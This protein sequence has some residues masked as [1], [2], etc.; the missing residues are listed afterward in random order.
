MTLLLDYSLFFTYF[1]VT[2]HLSHQCQSQGTG[3]L[4]STEFAVQGC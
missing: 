1:V 2:T 3:R 4:V